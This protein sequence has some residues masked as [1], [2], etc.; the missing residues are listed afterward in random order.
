VA[1]VEDR[2]VRAAEAALGAQNHV[3]VVDVLLRLQ[4]L[5]QSH[6]DRWRQGRVDFL[7]E[8]VQAGPA[9]QAKALHTF[10]EWARDRGLTPSE[11]EY[12]ARTT[13]RRTLRFSAIDEVEQ[14]YRTQWISPE[15]SPKKVD[16]VRA[17]TSAAPEL[18]VVAALK[19]WTCG[20]C[21]VKDD[22][23]LL[24]QDD[25]PLCLRCVGLDHLVFLP[26]GDAGR[27][28]RAHKASAL[29]AVVVRFSRTRRRYERQGLLVEPGALEA[30][31]NT[32]R[33]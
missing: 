10:Q 11:T 23:L 26:S 3:S 24:M 22:D 19:D 16:A 30:A 18:V 25:L 14:A 28:R 4:W 27:T 2:V 20:R 13:D 31:D 5:A 9:K 8:W 7:E 15:L 12:V 1:S 21:G 29:T 33:S 32:P 17:R 6:I